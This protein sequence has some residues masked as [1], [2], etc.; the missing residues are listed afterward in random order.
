MVI[1]GRSAETVEEAR[2]SLEPLCIAKGQKVVGHASDIGTAAG[3]DALAETA[4]KELGKIDMWINNA[5]QSQ[6]P[7]APLASTPPEVIERVVS[8]NLYGA[9]YGCRAAMIAMS[10]QG[11]G[12]SIFNV[13]GSGSRGNGTP[14][15]SAYG[16]SKAA[17]PQLGKTLAQETRGTGINVHLVSPGMVMTDLLLTGASASSLRI[18]NILAEKPETTAAWLVPRMRAAA[19]K[20][21]GL[22]IKYLT[23]TSV[24]WRF[25]TAWQRKDRLVKVPA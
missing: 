8:T 9:L 25:A 14:K 21:S 4:K 10:S 16:V 24:I 7:K 22:Y 3:A 1:H 18:F 17:L 11:S 13:D 6:H 20:P 19:E 5:G 12:G 15:S 2:K 23:P